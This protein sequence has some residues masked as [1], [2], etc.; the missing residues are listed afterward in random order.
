MNIKVNFMNLAKINKINIYFWIL[1]AIYAIFTLDILGYGVYFLNHLGFE[2][3]LIGLAIGISALVASIIQPLIGR[4]ADVRQYSW[5]DILIVLTVIMILDSLAMFVA[6]NS[7]RIYLFSLMVITVGCIYPFLNYGVFYYEHYGIKTD[8]G[9]SRG[10]ASLSY[11]IF[12]AITGFI[13]SGSNVMVINVF[14]AAS[15]IVMILVLFMFP[16]YGS[17]VE[18]VKKE[19]KGFMN[20]VLFKYPVFTLIFISVALFMVFNSLFVCYLINIFENVGGNIS[21]VAFANS[22][23]AL[24]ELPTMFLFTKILK[25]VSANKLLVAATLLYVV[26][27]LMVLGAHDTMGIYASILLQIVTYAIIIPAS[28]HLTDEIMNDEDKNEGQA[29]MG[30]TITIGLIFANLLGGNL[31]Q[32]F[33]IGLLL[34]ALVA[35]SVMGSLFALASLKVDG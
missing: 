9:V 21:D 6:P 4:L 2:Y 30:A 18:A 14:T 34:V 27:S 28:V 20:G 17:N 22:L 16:Y 32:F 7:I 23:G 8:F 1:Y 5:K 13:I 3:V 26:R 33:D 12:A 10:F 24:L 15:A 29:F 35:I 11:M 25:K 19:S 31:L